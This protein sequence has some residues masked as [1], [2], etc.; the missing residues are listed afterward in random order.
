MSERDSRAAP[1]AD[2]AIATAGFVVR[3]AGRIG[4]LRLLWYALV[5]LGAL[6]RVPVST[7]FLNQVYFTAVRAAP[8]VL[9]LGLLAG[10]FAITQITALAGSDNV[11]VL[12]LLVSGL[13]WEFSPLLTA[14]IL[15]ARSSP[16]IASELLLSSI[17][18]EHASLARMGVPVLEYLLVPRV[19]GMCVA[20]VVLTFCFAIAAVGGGLGVS[21]LF[22]HVAFGPQAGLLLRTLTLADLGGVFLKSFSF[23]VAVAIA[24]CREGFM[25]AQSFN[26]VPRAATRA[27]MSGLVAV[28]VL[29]AL[30]AFARYGL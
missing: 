17:H 8:V 6:G 11:L 16:A 29:N 5:R 27:V 26:D 15:I 22:Q 4:H 28:F 24:A 23:G 12:R 1:A 13:V 2:P 21:A 7:V 30:F 14:L 9:M 25:P 19:A 18:G 20:M 3:D 10:A